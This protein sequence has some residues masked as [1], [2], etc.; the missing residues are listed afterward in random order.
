MRNLIWVRCR[1]IYSPCCRIFIVF[2]CLS[3]VRFFVNHLNVEIIYFLKYVYR[4][5]LYLQ[6]FVC[7]R[8]GS[9]WLI[10]WVWP[11][12]WCSSCKPIS[13]MLV[14]GLVLIFCF[15]TKK[16]VLGLVLGLEGRVLVLGLVAPTHSLTPVVV[17]VLVLVL[18]PFVLAS[19]CS[20]LLLT[21]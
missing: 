12:S 16:Q 10:W 7:S 11:C 1:W 3:S 20:L 14:L 9:Y 2:Y 19:T 4:A 17:L 18:E 21:K 15:S 5:Y 8:Y 6:P 13:V